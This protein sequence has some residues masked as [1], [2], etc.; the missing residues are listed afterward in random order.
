VVQIVVS[1]I[2][3]GVLAFLICHPGLP[4]CG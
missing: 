1:R 4:S 2:P 3:F